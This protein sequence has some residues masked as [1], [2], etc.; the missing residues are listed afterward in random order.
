MR[1]ITQGYSETT[2]TISYDFRKLHIGKLSQVTVIWKLGWLKG[3]FTEF[4]ER[5]ILNKYVIGWYLVFHYDIITYAAF[6]LNAIYWVPIYRFWF[7][8]LARYLLVRL[9][10]FR[11]FEKSRS[12]GWRCN[13]WLNPPLGHKAWLFSFNTIFG[14]SRNIFDLAF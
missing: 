8:I 10:I 9:R 4:L 2:W 3:D 12:C 1:L 7:Q 11:V 6:R 13:L 14:I 5:N